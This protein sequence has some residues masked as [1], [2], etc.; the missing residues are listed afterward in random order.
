MRLLIV[1]FM[2]ATTTASSQTIQDISS[3][4]KRYDSTLKKNQGR[5]N[6]QFLYTL[7]DEGLLPVHHFNTSYLQGIGEFLEFKKSFH[8]SPAKSDIP[9]E[10]SPIQYLLNVL[11]RYEANGA[12]KVA[13]I[14]YDAVDPRPVKTTIPSVE[15][16]TPSLDDSLNQEDMSAFNRIMDS[17]TA[18][19]SGHITTDSSVFFKPLNSSIASMPDSGL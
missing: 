14:Y 4:S 17:V 18:A 2:L 15:S 9:D 3:V 19:D 16:T 7:R 13:F 6:E 5:Q 11:K 10:T 8:Y 12:Y 1:I